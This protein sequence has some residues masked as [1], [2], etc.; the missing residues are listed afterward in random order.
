MA[1]GCIFFSLSKPAMRAMRSK[2]FRSI[3]GFRG[4][5]W[6]SYVML[7]IIP[8]ITGCVC[9][10]TTSSSWASRLLARSPSFLVVHCC[11]RACGLCPDVWYLVQLRS[12]VLALL[13]LGLRLTPRVPQCAS[14]GSLPW[15]AAFFS[16]QGGSWVQQQ[17]QRHYTRLEPPHHSTLRVG[18][19]SCMSLSAPTILAVQRPTGS[20]LLAVHAIMLRA[21]RSNCHGCAAA[22]RPVTAPHHAC[23]S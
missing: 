12:L 13:H 16:A 22:E 7:L 17:R 15:C 21:A 1:L 11:V 19:P 4:G 6:C 2:V 18:P 8:D 5:F 20:G 14:V 9:A 10:A 3:L 23:C